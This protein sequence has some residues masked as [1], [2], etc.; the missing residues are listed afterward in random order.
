MT[1]MTT[2]GAEWQD[3]QVHPLLHIPSD[4]HQ[5]HPQSLQERLLHLQPPLPQEQLQRHRHQEVK[6]GTTTTAQEAAHQRIK[7][8]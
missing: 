6:T 4:Q 2:Q 8:A 5:V 1:T 7:E 3:Q